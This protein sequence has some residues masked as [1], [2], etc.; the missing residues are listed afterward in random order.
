M[1]EFICLPWS[2]V[3]GGM[4]CKSDKPSI[5]NISSS[6]LV[7]YCSY[8][9]QTANIVYYPLI[10]HVGSALGSS[11]V[12]VMALQPHPGSGLVLRCLAPGITGEVRVCYSHATAWSSGV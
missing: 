5:I 12:Q 10:P 8:Y 3:S 7:V 4:L 2:K 11:G 1:F 9:Y 6:T